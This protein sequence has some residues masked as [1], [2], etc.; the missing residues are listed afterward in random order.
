MLKEREKESGDSE[1]LERSRG[2]KKDFQG[3]PWREVIVSMLVRVKS[4]KIS[5]KYWGRLIKI[6]SVPPYE[7]IKNFLHN[8]RQSIL[9]S[10]IVEI[11]SYCNLRCPGCLR[12][13]REKEGKW[14]NRHMEVK[15]FRRIVDALPKTMKVFLHGIGEP[16]LHPALEELITIAYQ[17]GKFHFISLYTNALARH[18]DY[19]SHLFSRGLSG[20]TISVDSL[21]ATLASR[22]RSGTDVEK[23]RKNIGLLASQYPGRIKTS[24]VVGRENIASIPELLG[25]LNELGLHKVILQPF[26]DLG[27]PHG[28]LSL[29]ERNWFVHWI[30]AIVASSPSPELENFSFIPSSEICRAPWESPYIT[31]DG[32]LTPCCRITDPLVINFGNLLTTPFQ[33][34]WH[35]PKAEQWRKKFLQASPPVCAG[36]P[37]YIQRKDVKVG[38]V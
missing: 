27:T 18:P 26:D 21:E 10:I 33:E 34:I 5:Q 22:L 19:Y 17:A 20:L 23:L 9:T 31:I 12:S 3:H 32:F 37:M 38:S 1:V 29:E 2:K 4:A 30:K 8:I 36:C 25:D 28:W 6:L 35:G 7:I 13:I 24:T 11:T 16:T 15:D 14:E